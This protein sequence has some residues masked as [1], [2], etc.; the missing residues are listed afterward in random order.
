MFIYALI[1]AA[2]ENSRGLGSNGSDLTLYTLIDS[3]TLKSDTSPAIMLFCVVVGIWRYWVRI[4]FFWKRTTS[5]GA[6]RLLFGWTTDYAMI[7]VIIMIISTIKALTYVLLSIGS[8]HFH[9]KNLV[10]RAPFFRFPPL[11]VYLKGACP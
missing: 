10:K 8:I 4:F 7:V 2:N 6:K 1:N 9:P 5:L 3:T 11:K